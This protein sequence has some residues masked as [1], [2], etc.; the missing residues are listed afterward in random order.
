MKLHP[1]PLLTA[2]LCVG[3]FSSAQVQKNVPSDES[4][5]RLQLSD[6]NFIP[7]NNIAADKLAVVN[8][9]SVRV[10]KK[11]FAIIQFE[12]IPTETE[13]KQL[14]QA[15]I[16]L[17]DYV[18]NY[19]YTVTIK[20]SLSA[21]VLKR[22]KARAVIE[23][24][25]RQKMQ[26]DLANGI[27]PSHAVKIP[28]T[29]DVLISFPR[30]F[31][32]ETVS[33]EVKKLNIDIISTDWKSY[34]VIG[35]RIAANRLTELAG[36]PFVDYVEP[37]PK[38]DETL[39]NKSIPNSRANILQSSLPGQRNL[40]GEGVV[41]GIGDNADPL[42]HIDFVGRL[43]NRTTTDQNQHG[44]HVIGTTA[45]AGII[46]E[47]FAG[48]APKATIVAQAFSNILANA[49]AYVQDYGMVVTNNSYGNSADCSANGVYDIYSRIMDL[50]TFEMPNLQHVF[51]CGNW[52]QV[53]VCAPFQPGFN[54]IFGGYQTA[55]NV[56]SVGNTTELG[57]L[58][59]SSCRG[60]V[61]DGR[62]KPEITAQGTLVRSTWSI[63]TYSFNSGTSMSA[64]AVS[65]GLALLYQRYRQLHAGANPKNG[66]MKTLLLNGAQ[67]KGNPGPDFSYG[68]GWMNLLRSVTMLENNNYINDSVN[69][70]AVKTHT[71]TIP[72]GAS[73]AQLKVM[74]Y[75]NDA[76]ASVFA[77]QTLVNDLDLKVTIP[78]AVDSLPQ[79]LDT[80][81]A[82]VTK[83]AIT[84]VDHINN[85]EQVVINN[86]GP[87]TYTFSVAGTT[88]PMTP[89]YEYFIA[90]D[91]IPVSTTLTYPAGGERLVAGDSIYISWDAYG[92]SANDFTLQ[93]SI[94]NGGSW[95][96]ISPSPVA[97]DLRELKW[98][99]PIVATELAKVKLIH[100]GTGIES[101]SEAFTIL[102]ADTVSLAS[103]QCEG[104]IALNWT[105]VAGATDY[106]VMIQRGDDMVPLATTTATNYTIGGLSKDTL[107]CLSVRPRLNGKPGK[108]AYAVFRQPNTGTCAGSIS[109]NDLKIDAI[110]SP[111]SSGRKFTSTEFTNN[112]AI[113]VRIKNLDN[114]VTSGNVPVTYKIGAN[115]LVSETITAPNIAAGATY[116]YTF[117]ATADL[118]VLGTYPLTVTVSNPGDLVT[119]N[120]TLAKTFKQLDNQFIDLTVADFIDNIESGI[121]KSYQVAQTGLDG[122]D[123]YDFVTTS[124]FG[125]LRTF[126][127]SGI[128]NSGSKALTLDS[129]GANSGGT[130]DSLKGTF[131][132]QGFNISTDDIRLDFHFKHHGELSNAANRVWIR[133][134][135]T[136]PWI[137]VYDLFANQP[138]LG[139]FKKSSSIETGDILA[140]NS[141]AFTSSFQVRWGQWGQHQAA[142]NF[143]G[144]GYTFDDIHLYLVTD[145][146]Q[147]VTIDSP[148]V[149]NCGLTN[150]TPVSITIRNSANSAITN[151]PVTF[152]ADGNAPV[153][154]IIPSVAAN[155]T[156]SYTFTATADFSALGTHTITTWSD[157]A[158]DTYRDND[159]ATTELTNSPIISSF[160]YL[161]NFETDAGSWFT[162]GKNTSWEYGTPVSVKVNRAASGSKAWK[163]SL[164]GNYN[165]DELSYLYSPCFD[166][167]GM[168]SPTLSLSLALD[169]EDCGGSLCDGAYIE[170]SAD[171]KI[172]SRLGTA[173]A[174]T[175]WYNRNY[176]GNQLWSV[177]SYTRWH[178]AT[179]PLPTGLSRLRLRV[180]IVSDPYVSFEGVAIDDIHIYDNTN[181]IYT[182]APNSASINQ[183]VVNGTSWINFTDGG[184]LIA[185]INPNGQDLGSTNAQAYIYTGSTRINFQQYYHHRNITI[186][187]TNV[188]L[189]DSVTVRF[190]FTDLETE[191]LIN[192]TG[193]A[194]CSKPSSAYELGVS[195]Y[196][197]TDDAIE[198]GTLTDDV[199][200]NWLY[201]NSIK[202][203][204]VP[205]DRG[206]YAEFKVKDFSEFWL[207]NGGPGNNQTLPVE[208][209]SFIAIKQPNKDVVAK[210]VTA[211]ESNTMRYEVQVA[212][213]NDEFRQNNFTTIGTVS[214]SGNSATEKTYQFTDAEINKSGV[215]YYRLK[216]ID[217]DGK[218]TYSVIRPV[219][220]NEEIKW[221]VYPNPST[222]A[223]NLVYQANEGEAV[224]IKIYDV[225][226]KQVKLAQQIANGFV[227]K[228]EIDMIGNRFTAGMYLLEVTTGVEKRVF[229]LLK[230]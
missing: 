119:A 96:T 60:P 81:Y 170:Y 194:G 220:F 62:I 207:N 167:T 139:R 98:F 33:N 183:P 191:A 148:I 178:V 65:G 85:V 113:T 138:V 126:V 114:V 154:E 181:G 5:Y 120:D 141:Q 197:D 25:P 57:I 190:Y 188:N 94:N 75:W 155:A 223:F 215:R 66:L 152:K 86:P 1:I 89:R 14:Q 40:R 131:N 37:A 186:K 43:I 17:L 35:L 102:G 153:T 210:W 10:D 121:D 147:M 23:V 176:G 39:N 192:A 67:D 179:I 2:F 105:T 202:A 175:N 145:D 189:A 201:I 205:F 228:A 171:G 180:V 27:F 100:N 59:N 200:G 132:L 222:G 38:K 124:S 149:S 70:G 226:G 97:A 134:S 177:Q 64:P 209:V 107:Y 95:T 165:D 160:P 78:S 24:A 26:P 47:K 115:P 230:Q 110:I 74:L 79:I 227:Q 196:S 143:N 135:D 166:V 217:Q 193:C 164:V 20:D 111:A 91:T 73:I 125:R 49:P 136:Q 8:R 46:E 137:Q 54:N 206:Y 41:I 195:K 106:E 82:N 133:G 216:I 221:Q 150:A 144:T 12:A 51:A 212:K 127:N 174:G 55:K 30:T 42:K 224:T 87:G 15:G 3:F 99:V 56:I 214:T 93:Y 218:I 88:I 198:N 11:S 36:L 72:A 157:L 173:G 19:A 9:K 44:V 203:V 123:R 146:I 32:Y 22:L 156:I 130:A 6:A 172:W 208:L 151:V 229:R 13:R 92:N 16:E 109:D 116:D 204:K 128:A 103:V 48:Y 162:N 7:S 90:Y 159:T 104:Y 182:A 112:V 4:R 185:S 83:P 61:R 77:S 53:T 29:I 225:N 84:G 129:Y 184:R 211:S 18:P 63:Y 50:Q 45:G 68:F 169:L 71:I 213:G 199:N 28:G 34:N 117:T 101:I 163:T 21:T 118:S 161:Q 122:L 76:P 142:D 108:R 69:A 168:T 158:T 80:T 219:V 31:S 187:P 58:H 52:N 140:A